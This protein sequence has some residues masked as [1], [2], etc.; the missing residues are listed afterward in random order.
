L[1]TD[2]NKP[3]RI[4]GKYPMLLDLKNMSEEEMDAL[5]TKLLNVAQSYEPWAD[6]MY[7]GGAG[8]PGIDNFPL[9]L[10]SEEIETITVTGIPNEPQ[11]ASAS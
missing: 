5:R 3:S 9:D 10:F 1:V 8:D 11:Q 6:F 7:L 4:G 2:D